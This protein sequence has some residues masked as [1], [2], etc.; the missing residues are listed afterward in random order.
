MIKNSYKV[1]FHLLLLLIFLLIYQINENEEI[2]SWKIK[3]QI[4]K[5]EIFY[6]LCNNGILLNKKTFVKSEN[7]KISIITPIYNGSNFILRLLRSIQNQF[8]NEIEIIF[9]DDFSLDD[10]IKVV[11]KLQKE[12]ERI[13][14]IKNKVNKGTLITRNLGVLKSKGEYLT[15]PDV[16]D[17]FTKNIL[18]I[19]YKLSKRYNYE[20]IRFNVYEGERGNCLLKNVKLLKNQT[21]YQPE[22]STYIFY[23]LGYLKLSDFNVANKFIKRDAFIRTLNNI[24]KF[25]LTQKMIIYEDG[26]I[27]FALHR[28]INSFFLI[29]KIG[30]YYIF[31]KKKISFHKNR[32]I[33]KLRNFFLYLKFVF[34]N[35]KNNKYEK[36]MAFFLINR[37]KKNFKFINLVNKDFKFYK[38]VND[39]LINC[40]FIFKNYT[41]ELKKFNSI[42]KQKQ[43]IKEI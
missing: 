29:K 25:Y 34:E 23:G 9:I 19:C 11:Q 6:K 22:L 20:M 8:F 3:Q 32:R 13:I 38:N 28:N 2:Y 39:M 42:I 24:E 26:L 17:I 21:V 33:N 41:F 43:L 36:N 5:I 4:N 27:N 7:P 12:D 37:Y 15:F 35:S 18:K 30:Y 40:E 16:D 1:L 31:N 10:T 14:L